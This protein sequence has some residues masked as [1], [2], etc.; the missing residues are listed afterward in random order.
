MAAVLRFYVILCVSHV[1]CAPPSRP[2]PAPVLCRVMCQSEVL[3]LSNSYIDVASATA[4]QDD[5]LPEG[6]DDDTPLPEQVAEEGYAHHHSNRLLLM[7]R[8]MFGHH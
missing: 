7:Q 8:E 6:D 2:L 1:S 3:S 5:A 4:A